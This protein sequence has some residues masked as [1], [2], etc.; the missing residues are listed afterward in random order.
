MLSRR[1]RPSRHDRDSAAGGLRRT[2][3]GPVAVFRGGPVSVRGGHRRR[4]AQVPGT[5][6]GIGVADGLF[7]AVLATLAGVGT[8]SP[9]GSGPGGSTGGGPG[10]AS[11]SRRE[12]PPPSSP[13]ARR[14]PGAPEL[15]DLLSGSGSGPW[16]S[17]HRFPPGTSLPASAPT[18]RPAT[19]PPP[20]ARVSF[21]VC[22]HPRVRGP[23]SAGTEMPA[24][25][26]RQPGFGEAPPSPTK[27]RGPFSP[28]YRAT[29]ARRGARRPAPRGG[30]APS[31][32]AC[33]VPGRQ[34]G[35]RN[36]AGATPR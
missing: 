11:S 7:A 12:G 25:V 1:S 19:S 30:R 21:R 3:P 28:G 27:E 18:A 10:G 32:R 20:A 15:A 16:A 24:P 36:L 2:D 13:L 23:A 35:H 9:G 22:G 8:G 34:P 26:V 29:S 5:Q 14:C 33:M 17:S 4:F 6:V 31:E